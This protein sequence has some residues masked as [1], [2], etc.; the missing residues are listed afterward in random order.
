MPSIPFH[1][2]LQLH[3]AQALLATAVEPDQ[4]GETAV[5]NQELEIEGRGLPNPG[6][7]VEGKGPDSRE[8]S[9]SFPDLPATQARWRKISR[10]FRPISQTLRSSQITHMEEAAPVGKDLHKESSKE[11]LFK[12]ATELL[13]TEEA[14]VSRLHLVD[15]VFCVEL[16]KE[17]KTGNT[18]PEEVVKNIFSNISSIYLFHKQFFLPELDKRMQEW[19]VKPRIGDVLHKLAPFLKMYG[20]YVK[21]FDKAMDLLDTMLE[22]C[23]PFREIIQEIQEKQQKMWD[24]YEMLGGE[25]DIVDPS[26]ELLKEG[27]ILKVSV[28]SSSTAERHLFLFNKMLLYCAPKLSLGSVKFTV[29]NKLP[30]DSVQV[31]EVN[32][33]ETPHCF[34]VSGKQRS[35]QLQ[36]RSQ[37]EMEAWIQA[38]QESI[39]LSERKIDTFKA[40]SLG[41]A[42]PGHHEEEQELGKRAPRWIRDN[43]VTMC[44]RCKE[45]FNPITRRRHHCRACGYVVCGKCSDYK[46]ELQYD[47]NRTNRV[48]RDCYVVLKGAAEGD[49]REKEKKK[50]ILEKESAEASQNSLMCSFLHF[51]EGVGKAVL[52][53]WFVIP[54]EDP[55]VLYMYKAPQDVKAQTS[56]PLLGYSACPSANTDAGFGFQITQ[57][58]KVYT[59]I[60]ESAEQRE[61]WLQLV[62]KVASGGRTGEEEEEDLEGSE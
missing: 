43:H 10:T 56:I 46:A 38:I 15:Q 55:F 32:D 31:K 17:A 7:G 2:P 5:G 44:M 19:A 45:A 37:E 14:Y 12:I 52:K 42:S 49:D 39:V 3:S 47:E 8:N 16:M 9:I 11:K 13:Q 23:Q 22:K 53:A 29:R 57:S 1:S 40:A 48:C 4:R 34:L 41:P 27:P 59:F 62:R 35:L 21:N 30:V 6:L 25:E 61:R 28:R 36:A 60:A 18:F 24:V 58:K 50:G 20:E 33:V 26:N 51:T 54:R